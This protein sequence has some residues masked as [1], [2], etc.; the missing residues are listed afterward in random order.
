MASWVSSSFHRK[1]HPIDKNY[2]GFTGRPNGPSLEAA[3]EVLKVALENGMT[4]WNGAEFY[5]KPDYNSMTLVNAYFTKYPEDA[6]RVILSMKGCINTATYQPDGSP[7]FVRQSLDTILEQLDG[8]KKVDIFS[9]ARRDPITP[10]GVT[11][12]V[13]Q[14]EYID[15]GKIGGFALS[16]CSVETVQQAVR[17]TKVHLAELELSM[18]SPDILK[19]GIAAACAEHDITIIAYSPIGRGVSIPL[20]W[21]S[22][23]TQAFANHVRRCLQE[24]S[25][26]QMTSKTEESLRNSLA[27]R[28]RPSITTS[29][30]WSRSSP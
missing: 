20:Q 28:K 12:N 15:K 2:K 16:E 26:L 23:F 29:N 10:F 22:L 4:L 8:K 3:V 21:Q 30:S 1:P 14:K 5:G 6:D 27:S 17:H 24:S 13:I 18:F 25:S 7:E 19:N 9:C 11:V